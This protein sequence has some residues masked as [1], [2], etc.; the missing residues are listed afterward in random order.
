MT[1]MSSD[2]QSDSDLDSIRN[3]CD[4]FYQKI[5]IFLKQHQNQRY[6]FIIIKINIEILIDTRP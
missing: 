1:L 6:N 2:L 4:V 5:L 3:S